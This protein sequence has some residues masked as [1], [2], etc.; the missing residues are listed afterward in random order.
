M[1]EWE[2]REEVDVG[3]RRLDTSIDDDDARL[4]SGKKQQ[5]HVSAVHDGADGETQGHAEFVSGG[6]TATALGLLIERVW[7]REEE[8]R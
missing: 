3:R 4:E 1:S 8:R 7:W 2:E 5:T 6:T